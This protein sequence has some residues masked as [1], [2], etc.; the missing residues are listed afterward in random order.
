M[1]DS[2]RLAQEPLLSAQRRS[3]RARRGK[4][5][6]VLDRRAVGRACF[7][8]RAARWA[9]G[10]AV[11]AAGG[12]C[13]DRPIGSPDPVTT[14]IFVDRIT[15]TSVDKIDLLFMI[16]NSRSM[17]DKQE[18]LRLAVPDLVQRLVDPICVNSM[19]QQGAPADPAT[20][21]CE[22]GFSREFNPIEDINIAVI[23][24]SLGDVGAN[25]S[26]PQ[27]G[28]AGYIP[29]QVDMAHTIGSL[30]R[31]QVVNSNSRDLGFLEW[32]PNTDAGRFIRD[33]QDMVAAVQERGC[34][35][36]A[37]LEA[38][39]RFLVDPFPY[40]ELTRVSC[41]PGDPAESCVVQTTNSNGEIN[42]DQVIL[43]QRAAFLRDDSLVAIIMMTDENDCSMQVGNQLWVVANTNDT[44]PMFRSSSVCDTN[45]N[46]PCCYT[47]PV[48]PPDGCGPKD[49]I[50]NA[51]PSVDA[52]QDRLPESEDAG[53]LRCF[54]QKRRFGL[55]FLYPTQRYVNAL[56]QPQLCWNRP[57][58]SLVDCPED[59]RVNNPLYPPGGRSSS[60]LVFLGGILGVPWQSIASDVDANGQP[61]ANPDQVLR[62]KTWEELTEDNDW[63]AILGDPGRV[64]SGENAAVAPTPPT[65]AYMLESA[66]QRPAVP[67]PNPINGREYN[68]ITG[69]AA[70]G[71]RDDLQY[72]CIF[73]LAEPKLCDDANVQAGEICDCVAGD[74][75][76]P[77]CEQTPGVS[78]PGTTQYWAKAYPGLRQLQVLKDYGTNSIV[79]SIC[80]RNVT[81]PERSDFGYRPAIA[82]IVDRLKEQLGNRCLPRSLSVDSEDRVPC[83]LVETIPQPS[84]ACN[85]DPSIARGIPS[86]EVEQQI[87]AQLA[88]DLTRP[89]GEDDPS[90]TSACLCEVLQVQDANPDGDAALQVCQNELEANGVEGWCYVADTG[91]QQVGNAALV[92]D[93]PATERR[94]LR[95]VGQ[96]LRPNTTTFVACQGS[97]LAARQ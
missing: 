77:L 57:N 27:E 28:F 59:A 45:P 1:Q 81:A 19:G 96:G 67:N 47:C 36:E 50:C 54:D 58:L 93:C 20:G 46:D 88:G 51:D 69:N 9:L 71:T 83:T 85:C 48:G 78:A 91:D 56:I 55:D 87:R 94:L 22:T 72:S 66:V 80:A 16:D 15:Q 2:S 35:W 21:R 33:F 63:A 7:S 65:N 23:S 13:L 3:H 86:P 42:L 68:T 5:P 62:F 74:N 75:D 60:Q 52:A 92:E 11:L 89:C 40:E 73:P 90:C 14:N 82:A 24:S 61:L 84:G 38:W 44:R 97:S 18:I 4:P 79:A 76:R 6:G 8:H 29:D 12:G 30:A 64:A 70:V 25:A 39:Y 10:G 26:C 49:P 95:F 34:G 37:S 41:G 53:N 17:S 43:Q 31:G 32:R